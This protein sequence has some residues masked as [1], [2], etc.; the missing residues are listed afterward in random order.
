MYD[1]YSSY[2]VGSWGISP[3][4]HFRS[5]HTGRSRALEQSLTRNSRRRAPSSNVPIDVA[6]EDFGRSASVAKIGP[7]NDR[8]RH[9]KG[10]AVN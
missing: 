10:E 5:R 6:S 4:L 2:L 3:P 8:S 9:E 1:M 7:A